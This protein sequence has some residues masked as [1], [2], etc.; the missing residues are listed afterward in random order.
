MAVVASEQSGFVRLGGT[1]FPSSGVPAARYV[2][3]GGGV[4]LCEGRRARPGR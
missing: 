2:Q 3:L 1:V 4:V